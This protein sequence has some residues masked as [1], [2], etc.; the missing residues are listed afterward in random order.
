MIKFPGGGLELGEGIGN[1]LDREL[2]EELGLGARK[3]ELYFI[4]EH[5]QLSAFSSEDQIL[6]IYYRIDSKDLTS[7]L[8]A[9]DFRRDGISFS[10]HSIDRGLESV[11]C[12]P[13]DKQVASK[14][15]SE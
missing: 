6:S 10:W 8:P 4:N 5:F 9:K 3:K 15:S 1:A 13:I 12:M 7:I 14:I 2:M 11:M